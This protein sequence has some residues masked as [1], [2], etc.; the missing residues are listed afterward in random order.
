MF[1]SANAQVVAIQQAAVDGLIQV[2]NVQ[3]ESAKQIAD[4]QF[5]AVREAVE[6]GVKNVQS[7]SNVKDLNEAVALQAGV[8]KPAAVKSLA[9]TKRVYEIVARA[10]EQIKAIGEAQVAKVNE[11]IT[12][13]LDNA[14]QNAP[15]GSEPVFAFVKSTLSAAANAVDQFVKINNRIQAS[16]EQN[17]VEAFAAIEKPLAA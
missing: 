14:A 8:G 12:S 5:A 11:Q 17:I 1:D 16:V 9:L 2:A 13:A 6:E 4:L 3:I 7:L 15:A 10:N